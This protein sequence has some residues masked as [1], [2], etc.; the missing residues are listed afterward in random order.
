M[1]ATPSGRSLQHILVTGGTGFLGAWV[2]RQL[3]LD[4]FRVSAIK[5]K[6]SPT[7][8]FIE[9][10]L[11]SK[12]NWLEGDVL[13][14]IS[15]EDAMQD[16]DAVI[17]SAAVVSFLAADRKKMYTTNVEGTANVVNLALELGIKRV[18]L[19]SSVAAL[20]RT[21]KGEE[22]DEKKSWTESKSNTH[23]ALSKYWGEMEM[24]RAMAEGLDGVIVNP[25]T[26]IGYG[27]WNNSSCAI[28]RNVYEEFPW[29]SNGVNGFVYVEDVARAIVALLQADI[30]NERF[31][32]NGENWSFRQLF[33]TIAEGFGKKKPRLEATPLLSQ[34][35]W[36]LEKVTSWLNGKKPLL[37][38]ETAKIAQTQ[39]YFNNQKLL[40][41]LPGFRYTPLREAIKASCARYLQE[42]QA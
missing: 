31:I 8:T 15:L 41:Q 2:I 12:V 23:Y 38:K 24:W 29:Y 42:Q 22:V 13:D 39:T 5:R 28:F 32:L 37:S 1:T 3:V 33:D 36:R 7:P 6:D 35:A 14:L 18:V 40:Q 10:A 34:I 25:S 17:H 16:I 11:L 19:V 27:N 9:P 4:G 20:G 21:A 30:S 26:I